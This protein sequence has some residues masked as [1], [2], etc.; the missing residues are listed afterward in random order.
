MLG[1]AK[2]DIQ[3]KLQAV[4][5]NPCQETW[6]E[7]HCIILS[8]KGRMKTL[9]K[10]VIQIDPMMPLGK[11]ADAPWDYI[12]SSTTIKQAIKNTVF[13]QDTMSAS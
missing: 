1:T 2:P 11:H 6:E 13:E 12:P 10:A 4:I 9:W 8:N 7:A 3:Q 5:D